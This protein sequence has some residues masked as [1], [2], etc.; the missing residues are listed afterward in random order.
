MML[1]LC[2]R[3][4]KVI[5]LEV[6]IDL[7]G[8]DC[9]DLTTQLLKVLGI[10]K[11]S[12]SVARFEEPTGRRSSPNAMYGQDLGKKNYCCFPR[13][14]VCLKQNNQR[15]KILGSCRVPISGLIAQR[16][17]SSSFVC[18]S[19]D[20]H[21]DIFISPP[22]PKGTFPTKLQYKCGFTHA[23]SQSPFETLFF[24]PVMLLDPFAP[25]I[26]RQ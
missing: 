4:E 24:V 12:S 22:V 23:N 8:E 9:C 15:P 2:I 3:R 1:P 5:R 6:P 20:P 7:Y 21:G 25:R 26:N 10:R 14:G 13:L 11:P 19:F 16:L 17:G 18:K